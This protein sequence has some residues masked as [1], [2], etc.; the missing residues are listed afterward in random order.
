MTELEEFRAKAL[1]AMEELNARVEADRS[2]TEHRRAE[3]QEERGIRRARVTLRG[4]KFTIAGIVAIAAAVASVYDLIRLMEYLGADW[5]WGAAAGGAIDLGWIY[6]LLEVYTH[7][8]A[9]ARALKHY[10]RMNG[11]LLL[12]AALNAVSGVLTAGH[13]NVGALV[14]GVVSVL[15]PIMLKAVITPLVLGGSLA[16]ELLVT[17]AGRARVRDAAKDRHVRALAAYDAG[18][19]LESERAD[20]AAAVEL[21]R[22]RARF[23]AERES[24]ALDLQRTRED[25]VRAAF[26]ASRATAAAPHGA[27][28]ATPG[29]AIVAPEGAANEAPAPALTATPAAPAGFT[30]EQVDQLLALMS[31]AANPAARQAPEAEAPQGDTDATDDDANEEEEEIL[32]PLEPPTLANLS[33]ADAVRVAV[34]KRPNYS[35]RQIADLLAEYD[36]EVTDSYVRTVK[37]RD[38]EAAEAETDADVVPLRKQQ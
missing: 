12:S 22:Q 4:A 1:A 26:E 23:E 34:R 17:R 25:L 14:L 18:F 33:K 9:P 19:R 29:A 2:E 24:I 38:A 10:G 7:R 30:Q 5:W 35:S 13:G 36:V 16:S 3:E 27:T 8:S 28:S 32:P 11:L 31:Q 37:T 21:Q 6:L 20:H 15:M